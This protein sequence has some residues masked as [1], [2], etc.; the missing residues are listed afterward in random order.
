MNLTAVLLPPCQRLGSLTEAMV[1]A[2]G[3]GARGWW[4]KR[5]LRCGRDSV[6]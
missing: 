6:Q 4:R 2:G 3:L 1:S 5:D